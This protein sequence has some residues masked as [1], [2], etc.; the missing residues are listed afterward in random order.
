MCQGVLDAEVFNDQFL[1]GPGIFCFLSLAVRLSQVPLDI[2]LKDVE[3][4]SAGCALVG[5]LLFDEDEFFD[6]N[7]ISRERTNVECHAD[8][9]NATEPAWS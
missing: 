8:S 2:L 3:S 5:N 1:A 9:T 6:T 7:D 4:T